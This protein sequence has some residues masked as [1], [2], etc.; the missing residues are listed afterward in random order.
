MKKYI[1]I[2]LIIIS[3]QFIVTF[4]IL[5]QNKFGKLPSG[6]RLARVEASPNYKNGKFHNLNFTPELTEG[7]SMWRVLK[8]TIFT[9]KINQ[10]P[11][12]VPSV[13]V[14]LKALEPEEN[15]LIWL[16]HSSY[17]LQ[18]DG[19]KILIDPVLS[20]HASPFSFSIKA[21]KGSDPYTY[22]D[23]PEIDYLFIT[24][25]HWDHLDY[26][27]MMALKPK[28]KK[29]ICGLG[30]GSH[31]EHWNFNNDIIFE[32]DWNDSII[33]DKGFVSHTT[34]SRHF[35]GRGFSRNKTLWVSF[36]LKTPTLNLFFGGD[37]G[38]DTHFA[39][40]GKKFGSFDI[41][42]LENGQY[43]KAWRYIHMHPN[44]VLKAGSDLKT[45][46]VLP[47]HSGKFDLANHEW[48]EPLNT[49]SNLYNN[50]DFNLITP[51]IGEVVHLNSSAKKYNR[52]WKNEDEKL[53][54]SNK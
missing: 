47:G 21:F 43:D 53:A 54:A 17:F 11:N 12:E 3:A 32:T 42:L 34:P 16:G 22:E 35:S 23:I 38:Y 48:D 45:K 20:G 51:I 49:I 10:K 2:F 36:V 26:K 4:I 6:E 15:I 39:E 27:S 29:I 30:V 25:D 18:A 52:W 44:E 1:M 28:L 41:A 33:L 13:K 14:D 5:G 46:G 24:H 40:I 50:E 9:K 8:E 19:K 7:Y 31:F 37:S